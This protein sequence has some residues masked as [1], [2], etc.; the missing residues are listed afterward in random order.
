MEKRTV[1]EKDALDAPVE[2]SSVY[3]AANVSRCHIS[4]RF[5]GLIIAANLQWHEGSTRGVLRRGP[6]G[7]KPQ[8][9]EGASSI[10]DSASI[11]SCGRGSRVV[12]VSD[13]DWPCHEFEP[14]ITK[15]PPCRAA[16]HVKS[17]ENSNVLSPS[18]YGGYDPWLVT[19]WIRIPCKTWLY[20]LRERSRSF[21]CNGFPSRKE[22]SAP[23]LVICWDHHL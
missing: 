1:F 18:Q 15:D 21:T 12:K 4:A 5:K 6:I 20:L 16:M 8:P 17:V 11:R 9:G 22:S 2:L 13:R 3:V 19:E 7:F 14:S 23:L 10:L